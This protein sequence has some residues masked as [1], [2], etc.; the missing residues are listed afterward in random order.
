MTRVVAIRSQIKTGGPKL[1]ERV[2]L[3]ERR[4]HSVQ[5]AMKGQGISVIV[6][7]GLSSYAGSGATGHG[8]VRY[9]TDW[10]SR[11]GASVIIQPLKGL[12]TLIVPS[13]H[14]AQYIEESFP[15]VERG[16]AESPPNYGALVH[17]ILTTL[18]P[19]IVGLVNQG[20][21]PRRFYQDM[22]SDNEWQLTVADDIID[23]L[24]ANKDGHEIERH[25]TAARISDAMFVRLVETL[26]HYRG[27][28][29]KLMVEMEHAGREMG[30]E[31]ATC[32]LGVGQPV[33][34]CHYRIEE[35]PQEIRKGDQVLAGTYVT[36]KGYWGHCIRMGAIGK[37][38]D[39]YHRVY[40]AVRE[41]NRGA[42]AKIRV[43]ADAREIQAEAN[44]LAGTLLPGGAEHPA[45]SRHAH[46]LGLDYAD[47]PTSS[48]FPQPSFWSQLP[49][50]ATQ[51]VV[52]RPNMVLEVHT[53]LGEK[54]GNY[55]FLGDV[56]LVRLDKPERLTQFPQ[57][58]FVID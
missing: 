22:V 19:M 2:S 28:A 16:L 51:P 15:W 10:T 57:E 3:F 30:A 9:L 52:L 32:W 21:M 26:E 7:H 55:G 20:D 5:E 49:V 25:R 11:F 8:Y 53:M 42:V 44:L 39:A 13:A 46:F 40:E 1:D 43:G 36:Y 54:G 33:D 58:L 56:Y 35:L 23:R 17:K 4:R 34:R 48:A 27:P 31:F 12:P 38:S 29:W 18:E 14:D 24:R 47:K 50:P 41:Q 45:R 6:A 37:P